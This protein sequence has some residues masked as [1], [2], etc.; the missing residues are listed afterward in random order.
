MKRILQTLLM[1]SILLVIVSCGDKPG[2]L[3]KP[4]EM[5]PD[6]CNRLNKACADAQYENLLK[7][8]D[9]DCKILLQTEFNPEVHRG[10]KGARSYFSA[11]AVDTKF[12][13]GTVSLTGLN[14][15]TEYFF[16]Q[17][18]GVNGVGRWQ[19]R[20]NNMGKIR[21]LTIIPGE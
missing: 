4:E 14:A 20:I 7:L 21:E 19:F 10:L 2:G 5:V 17:P 13:I 3:R 18:N 12:E 11:I 1:T 8:F 9:D 15:V 6:F 16:L